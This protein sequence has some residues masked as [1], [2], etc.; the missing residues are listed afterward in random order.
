MFKLIISTDNAAFEDA[1]PELA[2]ILHHIADHME[3]AR[4]DESGSVF[5][6]NGNR[7]GK[8]TLTEGEARP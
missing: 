8:W 7:V 5:D 3:A 4:A 6:L 2:R 1:G